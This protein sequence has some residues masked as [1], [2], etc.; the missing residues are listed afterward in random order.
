MRTP[1]WTPL[2][3]YPV[4][5]PLSLIPKVHNRTVRVNIVSEQ[6]IGDVFQRLSPYLQKRNSNG[7]RTPLDILDLWP[8]AGVLSSKINDYLQPRRHVLLEPALK[9]FGQFL[10]P[11]AASKPCYTLENMD[12]YSQKNWTG[13][14]SRLLPEQE[15]LPPRKSGE[16]RNNDTLLVLANP[17]VPNSELN[18]YTPARWWGA[19]M[20]DCLN[21]SGLH[22]YGS[23]RMLAVM[24]QTE[25]RIVLPQTMADRNRP[26]LLTESVALNAIEAASSSEDIS[27]VG[28]KGLSVYDRIEK[29]VSERGAA[30]KTPPGREMPQI[31]FA[32]EHPKPTKK[33]LPHTPRI[34]TELH[35]N[36]TKKMNS[37]EK[38]IASKAR[39]ALGADNRAAYYRELT[40]SKQLAIDAKMSELAR[41]AACPN[42]PTADLR[43]IDEKIGLLTKELAEVIGTI[44]YGIL[45]IK[46]RLI[47][48]ERAARVGNANFD[49]A[50]LLWD[51]RPFE[52][53]KIDTT[54]LYPREPMSVLFFEADENCIAVRKLS[55]VA[56]E[57]RTDVARLFDAIARV[58][59]GKNDMS[60]AEL[61]QT[62]LP[63]LTTDQ[64]L[65]EIPGLVA[66]ADKRL[67]CDR[68]EIDPNITRVGEEDTQLLKMIECDFSG[69]RVRTLSAEVLWDI[70]LL[71]EQHAQDLSALQLSR[72]IGATLTTFGAGESADGVKRM[73]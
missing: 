45:R 33:A 28:L 37:K 11:L 17:A 12:I 3:R 67:R 65:Q 1:I 2:S 63:N 49:D 38:G 62:L 72:V 41:L 46:D 29:R 60:V 73:H 48:E 34:S 6:L 51:R 4:T 10:E 71:Y 18:H 26:A 61:L 47:D 14:F 70:I 52:P 32:P 58:F 9:S 42:T 31:R 7:D 20:E 64:V 22:E 19:L 25:A 24:P 54:E 35:E 21:Q 40:I 59:R 27:W 43:D 68:G 13:V 36:L 57:R 39:T 69:W 30:F 16:M 23:V 44:H 8:G 15:P 55:K 53:L 5:E 56:E 50:A 66:Y